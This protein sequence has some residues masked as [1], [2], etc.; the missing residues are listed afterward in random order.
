MKAKNNLIK[1]DNWRETEQTVSSRN[2]G[3]QKDQ[4]ELLYILGQCADT[5]SMMDRRNFH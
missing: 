3:K 5:K 1:T 4:G 2:I